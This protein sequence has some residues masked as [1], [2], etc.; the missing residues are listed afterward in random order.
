MAFHPC[1]G[2]VTSSRPPNFL[3]DRVLTILADNLSYRNNGEEILRGGYF[4]AY[5]NVKRVIRHSPDTLL[6][7]K[8][9]ATA[10]LS[11]PRGEAKFS[12]VAAKQH[13]TLIQKLHGPDHSKPFAR[14]R[15]VVENA[16]ESDSF[17]FRMEQVLTVRVSRLHDANRTFET[18]FEPLV[19][20]AAFFQNEQDHFAPLLTSFDPAVFPGILKSYA[21]I[22]ELATSQIMKVWKAYDKRLPVH[23]CEALSAIDRV[24]SACFTGFSRSLMPSVMKPLGI[25]DSLERRAWPFLPTMLFQGPLLQWPRDE[26]NRPILMHVAALSYHYNP[27]I[28]K[29]RANNVWL[30]EFATKQLHSPQARIDFLKE[31]FRDLWVPQTVSFI[32]TQFYRQLPRDASRALLSEDAIEAE[33]QQRAKVEQ[34]AL[35]DTPFSKAYVQAYLGRPFHL[36]PCELMHLRQFPRIFDE[37]FR[38][39]KDTCVQKKSRTDYAT[40][41]FIVCT[42]QLIPTTCRFASKNSTWL[43]VLHS[44]FKHARVSTND[45]QWPSALSAA[46]SSLSIDYVPGSTGGKLTFRSTICL[47]PPLDRIPLFPRGNYPA[48][49]K[50]AA[51]E[52][53]YR[54]E[55][56]R[57]RMTIRTYIDF[58]EPIPFARVPYLIHQGL[59]S[60][61][62]CKKL[63]NQRVRL[64]YQ[65]AYEVLLKRSPSPAVDV[66]LIFAL[67]LASSSKTPRCVDFRKP[68]TFWPNR[69]EAA[70]FAFVIVVR[71]L[72]FL[73]PDEFTGVAPEGMYSIAEMTKKIGMTAEPSIKVYT[74]STGL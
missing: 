62:D 3:A 41:L 18:V 57:P 34:W 13:D 44:L 37:C 74:N 59:T 6:A 33:K 14:E 63:S 72:W 49:G 45:S 55:M 52:A 30:L 73:D 42:S 48:N 17:S 4:Q 67:S 36:V 31:I 38:K 11:L 65:K 60:V 53:E 19:R 21:R 28:A 20:I 24:G 71:M 54:N 23:Y 47:S 50:R 29:A 15:K 40:E 26:N 10:A 64:H 27:Q 66:I 51:V 69:R 70:E 9:I 43:S 35:H 2:N 22:F 25:I 7:T 56:K 8:G 46:L 39:G 68:W 58:G 61:L 1:Y 32:T 12:H 5:S 16:M